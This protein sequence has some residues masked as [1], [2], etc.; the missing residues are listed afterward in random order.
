MFHRRVRAF[1]LLAPFA[2]LA[3]SANGQSVISAR[4]GVVHFFEGAV[5]LNGVALEPHL[6]TFPNMAQGAELRTAQGRAEVLLTPGVVVRIG[7]KSAIRMVANDL[8]DTRVELLTGSVIVESAEPSPGT[9]VTFLYK[10]WNVRFP[11]RGVYR[12]DSAPPRLWV[13][14]GKAEVSAGIKGQPVS[15]EQGT[16]VPFAAVLVPERSIGQP[17]DALSDWAEGRDQ[18]ISADNAIAAN[19]QDPDSMDLNLGLDSFTYFPMLGLPPPA[20]DLSSSFNSYQA[21]Y[22]PLYQPGFNSIYLPGYTYRPYFLGLMLPRFAR[23]LAP[24][25]GAGFS[26]SPLR[27]T[28]VPGSAFTPS[29]LPGVGF[30]PSPLGP[31]PFPRP[32][33]GRPPPP[34]ISVRPVSPPASARPAPRMGVPAG[35]R[36]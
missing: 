12:I 1:S 5:S 32:T 35:A 10:D 25:P 28:T 29:H 13:P 36:R 22:Q 20:S 21:I 8:A 2:A 23:P 3:L 9:S 18:S 11:E 33:S 19:I 6:G 31:A 15:V 14:Q 26:T 16:Y 27:F 4:S 34:P 30:T 17:R 7:E 24:L